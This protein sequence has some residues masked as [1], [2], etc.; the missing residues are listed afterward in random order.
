VEN[1]GTWVATLYTGYCDEAN[2][3]FTG[4][5][6]GAGLGAVLGIWNEEW[7]VLGAGVT[8]T[9]RAVAGNELGIAGELSASEALEVVHARG[10]RVLAAWSSG[11]YYDGKAALS[12]NTF[13][14]GRAFYVAARFDEPSLAAFHGA[15]AEELALTTNLGAALPH[16]VT[17]QRRVSAEREYVF[18]L[19]FAPEPRRPYG[20]VGREA[21]GGIGQQE[22]LRRIDEIEQRARAPL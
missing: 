17:A 11:D 3:C 16:G 1:G 8:R 5:L 13:G 12:V 2:R 14:R 22:D 18:L 6:P 19:N 21:G 4:G 7:D 15:L 20:I 9:A 10:A